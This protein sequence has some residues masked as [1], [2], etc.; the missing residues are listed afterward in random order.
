MIPPFYHSSYIYWLVF[1]CKEH[2]L[3]SWGPAD[4]VGVGIAI[5]ALRDGEFLDGPGV[6]CSPENVHGWEGSG[7]DNRT[8]L[9]CSQ[10]NHRLLPDAMV[11]QDGDVHP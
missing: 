6:R 9:S 7:K 2:S 11:S 1:L 5:Q 4:R 3:I 8:P 10:G